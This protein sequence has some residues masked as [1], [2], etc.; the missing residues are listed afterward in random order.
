[1]TKDVWAQ[2][3]DSLGISLALLAEGSSPHVL[4]A[5]V[6]V[7]I[8]PLGPR[9][10]YRLSIRNPLL[11]PCRLSWRESAWLPWGLDSRTMPRSRPGNGLSWG[12]PGRHI[13]DQNVRK[14]KPRSIGPRPASV[15]VI[16]RS[17]SDACGLP[18]GIPIAGLPCA[19]PQDWPRRCPGRP[20]QG[21]HLQHPHRRSAPRDAPRR[22]LPYDAPPRGTC[23]AREGGEARDGALRL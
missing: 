6:T 12:S 14:V 23:D 7:L 3:P 15:P 17:V 13:I 2:F 8:P 5:L 20:G 21:S 19:R 22:R 9:A 16:A 11:S 4:G 1:M 10:G 18:T